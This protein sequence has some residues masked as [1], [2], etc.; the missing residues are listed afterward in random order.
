MTWKVNRSARVEV[1]MPFQIETK[2]M[3]RARNSPRADE[4]T[5]GPSEPA[6]PSAGDDINSPPVDVGMEPVEFR[7]TILR[8]ADAMLD[9]LAD[10]LPAPLSGD[11]TQL[12]QLHRRRLLASGRNSRVGGDP[13]YVTSSNV[14]SPTR[15]CS[16]THPATWFTK[17]SNP[18]G[19]AI[20]LL[21]ASSRHP[22]ED[23]ERF[24]QST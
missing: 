8:A 23:V 21:R 1:S 24:L 18:A 13:H 7:P 10:H 22:R 9:V 5:D 16:G 15:K 11:L 2:S 12:V 6:K 19:D 14:N 20:S 3:P 17:G 4:V